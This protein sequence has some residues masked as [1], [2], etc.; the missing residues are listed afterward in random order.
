MCVCVCVFLHAMII[1]AVVT[2]VLNVVFGNECGVCV[3]KAI[4]AS[5]V[6]IVV[7]VVCVCVCVCVCKTTV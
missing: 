7:L 5:A 4:I 2:I 3:C 1:S 6:A